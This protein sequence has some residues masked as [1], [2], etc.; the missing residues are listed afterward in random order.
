MQPGSEWV[1]CDSKGEAAC[2]Y[3]GKRG[4]Y[5]GSKWAG[6]EHAV[7]PGHMGNSIN[8]PPAMIYNE[9][10]KAGLPNAR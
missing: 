10:S 5:R 2:P 4:W 7:G 8:T 1:E 9:K 6:C 3:C